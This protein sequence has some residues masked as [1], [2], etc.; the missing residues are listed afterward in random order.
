M[1]VRANVALMCGCPIEPG[2][3]WDADTLEVEA[4]VT[5]NGKR[6]PPVALTYRRRDQSVLGQHFRLRRRASTTSRSMLITRPTAIPAW[7]G[8][9]SL[10]QKNE[11]GIR[12]L[13]RRFGGCPP[14]CPSPYSPGHDWT[15]T[16]ANISDPADVG[17]FRGAPVFEPCRRAEPSRREDRRRRRG[18]PASHQPAAG[19]REQD[20]QDR[21]VRRLQRAHRHLCQRAW[22]RCCCSTARPSRSAR[23]SSLVIDKFVYNPSTGTGELAASFSKGALRFVGGK[24]SKNEPGVKVKTPAGTLTVRGGIFQGIVRSSNQ[25]VFAF[26]FGHHLSLNRHGRRYTLNQTGNLFAIGSPGAPIMRPTN[27]DRH[28]SH[29]R[30]RLRAQLRHEALSRSRALAGRS[31]TASSPPA[32]TPTSLSSRSSITTAPFTGRLTRVPVPTVPSNIR[33]VTPTRAAASDQPTSCRRSR[34]LRT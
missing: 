24:L 13:K 17:R 11:R 19:R 26:V 30:R 34:I 32:A 23:S 33:H 4:I 21:Q 22:C 27:A 10:W 15:G 6:L 5:R 20:P 31:I 28:Q 14:P 12:Y 16:H 29:S 9:L 18:H 2:K 7:T 3:L 8:R 25:A 1:A